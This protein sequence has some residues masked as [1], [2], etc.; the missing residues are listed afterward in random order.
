MHD[1]FVLYSYIVLKLEN[2]YCRLEF[3]LNSKWNI[4]GKLTCLSNK[5]VS[6]F[7]TLQEFNVVC[8]LKF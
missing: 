4:Y 5:N 7:P 3:C 6:I 1:I 2:C 8:I